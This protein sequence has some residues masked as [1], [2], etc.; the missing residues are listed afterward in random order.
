[1]DSPPSKEMVEVIIYCRNTWLSLALGFDAIYHH[2][3]WRH[4]NVN[5][6]GRVFLMYLGTTEL[7]SLVEGYGPTFLIDRTQEIIDH[8]LH[9][10][11]L[12]REVYGRRMS[13]EPLLFYR[14][15]ILCSLLGEREE[16]GE[17]RNEC[18]TYW[19]SLQSG[20]IKG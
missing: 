9:S 11:E 17:N 20:V 4:S 15:H 3:V 14:R 8:N 1:M 6:R 18:S 19:V 12:V 2:V 16:R 7:E 5:P 10:R 13:P